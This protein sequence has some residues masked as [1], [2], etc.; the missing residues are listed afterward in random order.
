[1]DHG[2]A[3][4]M[5]RRARRSVAPPCPPCRRG[6]LH[7]PYPR[8]RQI[9]RFLGNYAQQMNTVARDIVSGYYLAQK[10]L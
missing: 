4:E 8:Q 10:E 1:M 9:K 5:A 7:W 6:A 3:G 2:D